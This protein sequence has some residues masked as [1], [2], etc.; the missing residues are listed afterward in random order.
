[1]LKR[2]AELLP[3]GGDSQLFLFSKSGFEWECRERALVDG[4]VRLVDFGEML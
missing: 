4:N 1:M 3:G 2:R